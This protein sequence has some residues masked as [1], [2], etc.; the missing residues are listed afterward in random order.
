MANS[1][2][3]VGLIPAFLFSGRCTPISYIC[4]SKTARIAI[5]FPSARLLAFCCWFIIRHG[6]AKN[7]N[8]KN[9]E[10]NPNYMWTQHNAKVWILEVSHPAERFI[11]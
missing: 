11:S 8:R 7:P 3:R 2:L 9:G 6:A 10:N 5:E 1:G 4:V